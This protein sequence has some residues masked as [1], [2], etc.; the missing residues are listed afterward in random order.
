MSVPSDRGCELERTSRLAVAR[1]RH[2]DP[3]HLDA[4]LE[5]VAELECGAKALSVALL[6][7]GTVA[8]KERTIGEE[9]AREVPRPGIV[10]GPPHELVR[11]G[12]SAFRLA[13]RYV[14]LTHADE[15]TP[16]ARTGGEMLPG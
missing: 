1:L 7:I 12:F 15:Y 13:K 11:E 2:R 16:L 9:M 14:H 10:L 6:R 3:L 5:D 4:R 8:A